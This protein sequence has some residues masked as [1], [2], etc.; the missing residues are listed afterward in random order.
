MRK[1]AREAERGR[2]M[3]RVSVEFAHTHLEA[4]N[5]SDVALSSHVAGRVVDEVRRRG[6]EAATCVL[7]DDKRP[8]TVERDVAISKFLADLPEPP[9]DFICFESELAAYAD[10]L[11]ELFDGG[12]KRRIGKLVRDRL[13]KFGTLP[14]SVAC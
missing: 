4:V 11:V 1:D 9:V 5:E 13:A 10:D 12:A 2:R 8:M 6:H 3:M 14:C 7:V